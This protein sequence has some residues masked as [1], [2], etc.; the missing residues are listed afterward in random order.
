MAKGNQWKEFFYFTKKHIRG[1]FVLAI[2]CLIAHL[3]PFSLFFTNPSMQITDFQQE[4]AQFEQ[5]LNAAEQEKL[6]SKKESPMLFSFNPNTLDKSGFLQLGLSEK[7]AQIILNYR[8]KGGKF[9]RKADLKKIYGLSEKDYERLFPYIF[10]FEKTAPSAQKI[11]PP[12]KTASPPKNTLQPFTFNP[13]TILLEDLLKMGWHQ[14]TAQNLIK[15]RKAGMVFKQKED[16]KKIYG[17]TE[18]DYEKNCS[19]RSNS[20]NTKEQNLGRKTQ[21]SKKSTNGI[22]T[23]RFNKN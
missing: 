1:I 17:M 16:L 11:T 6:T 12:T 9:Y 23:A 10:L 18:G 4:I 20:T 2:L 14:K 3:F 5:Q 19:F 22:R 8:N 21:Y 15:Y 13:N 7:V